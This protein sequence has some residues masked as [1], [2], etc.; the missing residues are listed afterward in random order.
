MLKI[1]GRNNSSNVQK[2]VWALDEMKVQYE[3]IDAGGEFGIVN[4]EPYLKMNPNARVPTMQEDDFILW[5]SNAIVDIS[6]Q[7]MVI[8]NSI[9]MIQKCGQV[10]IVGWTG[11]KPP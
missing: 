7:N 2:V 3:R 5:E 8:K 1:H 6:L 10:P 9:Q 4:E 11:S